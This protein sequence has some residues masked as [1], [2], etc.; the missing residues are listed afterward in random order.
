M[1]N[2][3]RMGTFSREKQ[4]TR[5]VRFKVHDIL[6]E[7]KM[8]NTSKNLKIGERYSSIYFMPDLTRNQQQTVLKLR[9]KRGRKSDA[10]KE[11]QVIQKE[12]IIKQATKQQTGDHISIS[13]R[14]RAQQTSRS[15]F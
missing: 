15:C 11:I 10:G 4:R 14:R 8:L 7:V 12:K 6:R 9:D 5:P 3:F 1:G 2:V 13:R